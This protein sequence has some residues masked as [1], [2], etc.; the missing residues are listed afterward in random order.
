[1]RYLQRGVIQLVKLPH[2]IFKC[3]AVAH[4]MTRIV[5]HA[6]AESHQHPQIL[7]RSHLDFRY[8]LGFRCVLLG[9]ADMYVEQHTRPT[10]AV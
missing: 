10:S 7:N 5:K 3:Q 6:A 8:G 9:R 4:A 1:M 2:L